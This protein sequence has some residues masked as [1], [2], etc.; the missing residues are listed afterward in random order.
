MRTLSREIK[1][2]DTYRGVNIGHWFQMESQIYAAGVFSE[3]KR[4]LFKSLNHLNKSHG[5]LLRDWYWHYSHC[6]EFV[7]S[8]S[9]ALTKE[10]S[11]NGLPLGEWFGKQVSLLE[12]G[13][14]SA[15][16]ENAMEEFLTIVRDR[17]STD[18]PSV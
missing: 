11:Y 14:L 6:L 18:S 7:F 12:R 10:F 3:F 5:W 13:S 1:I 9:S 2:S 15:R 4:L 17:E 16:Q 8:N